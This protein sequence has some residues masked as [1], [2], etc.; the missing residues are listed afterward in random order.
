MAASISFRSSSDCRWGGAQASNFSLA[1]PW[2]GKGPGSHGCR[3]IS[4]LMPPAAGAKVLKW[5]LSYRE[6]PR[7]DGLTLRKILS[8]MAQI[9]QILAGKPEIHLGLNQRAMA[10]SEP[11]KPILIPARCHTS[12]LCSVWGSK[13]W[14]LQLLIMRFSERALL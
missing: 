7:R 12:H 13:E 11:G 9:R 10:C 1:K 8:C 3:G 4:D 6:C 5:H 2:P 14:R